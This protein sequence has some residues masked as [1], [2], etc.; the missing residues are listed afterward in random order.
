[1]DPAIQMPY[2]VI[3]IALMG[4]G[5]TLIWLYPL[6]NIQKAMENGYLEIVDFPSYRMVI[7]HCYV[8]S[9]EGIL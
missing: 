5:D 1:M 3:S 4:L 6:V 2:G 7:F 9:P 8:S